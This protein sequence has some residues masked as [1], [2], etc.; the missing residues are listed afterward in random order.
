MQHKN[1]NTPK[2]RVTR[3]SIKPFNDIL[4]GIKKA[5]SFSDLLSRD[6]I[7]DI[8]SKLDE[9]KH[10]ISD[11]IVIYMNKKEERYYYMITSDSLSSMITWMLESTKFD[12]LK[13]DEEEGD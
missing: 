9:V 5:Q 4:K 7:N 13:G 10:D 1:S 12:I 8:L 2:K 6:E 11:M 3:Q